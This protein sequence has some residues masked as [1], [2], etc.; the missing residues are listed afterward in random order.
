MGQ[1]LKGNDRGGTP[2]HSHDRRE[3]AAASSQAPR[4]DDRHVQ[5]MGTVSK[6]PFAQRFCSGENVVDKYQGGYAVLVRLSV[7]VCQM[8][9]KRLAGQVPDACCCIIF[10]V[11]SLFDFVL[12]SLFVLF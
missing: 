12:T 9:E 4:S 2:P 8:V 11:F 7:F 5:P 6:P 1:G 10:I 3:L